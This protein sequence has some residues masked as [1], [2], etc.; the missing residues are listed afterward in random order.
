MSP[1]GRIAAAL[2]L[3]C[4]TAGGAAAYTYRTLHVFCPAHACSGGAGP[5]DLALDA[6]GSIFG[7]TM[8][9]GAHDFGTVFE[10]AKDTGEYRVI[11]DFCNAADCAD[12]KW[13]YR[14]KLVIDVQGNLYGTT[15]QGGPKDGGVVFELV[16]GESGWTYKVLYDF[17]ALPDCGDGGVPATG[18]AYVGAA[19]GAP[20]DG[21]SPLYG[22]TKYG[23]A[24]GRGIVY[25]LKHVRRDPARWQQKLLYTF[26]P[27]Q[28]CADGTFPS[29]PVVLDAKADLYGTTE[30]G[31]AFGQGIVYK[32]RT[33]GAPSLRI[34]H[35]FCAETGCADG[36]GPLSGLAMDGA[37]NLFGAAAAGGSD[38]NGVL[39]KLSPQGRRLKYGVLA[40][41]DGGGGGAR[42]LTVTLGSGGTLFGTAAAGGA[43]QDGA[44]FRYDG[45]LTG[46]YGFCGQRHCADGEAA[47]GALI[48]DGAGALIGAASQG[49]RKEAG[50]L[51][52]LSP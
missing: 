22:T 36:A 39:F 43:H 15:S 9:G 29:G 20:Y 44:A 42:P 6:S 5:H 10:Y 23:G 45:T 14:V 1:A 7:T 41:F 47:I 50:T 32:L 18:L 24:F 33:R 26:C 3:V 16:R 28:G 37:G 13:P 2:A 4:A 17:C 8:F 12:G 40:R 49:G 21:V 27:A 31:G 11:H 52:E 30:L 19:S 46:I 51:Y 48:E 38:D 34:A 35:S 25:A